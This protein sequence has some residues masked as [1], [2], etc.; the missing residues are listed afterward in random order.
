MGPCNPHYTRHLAIERSHGLSCDPTEA[1]QI[2]RRPQ[3]VCGYSGCVAWASWN[4]VAG[5]FVCSTGHVR[6]RQGS[7]IIM[8]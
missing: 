5:C 8:R 3:R 7:W 6:N 4:A 1:D 2:R